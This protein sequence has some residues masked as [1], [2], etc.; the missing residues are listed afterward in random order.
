MSQQAHKGWSVI[1]RFD[2]IQFKCKG[3]D[4][5]AGRATMMIKFRMF[6]QVYSNKE[7]LQLSSTWQNDYI[8]VDL[9]EVEHHQEYLPVK[10]REIFCICFESVVSF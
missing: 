10:N 1:R 4:I 7:L 6:H 3:F 9:Y 2:H 8:A 5:A